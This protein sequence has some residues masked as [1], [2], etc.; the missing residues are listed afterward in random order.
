[1]DKQI[2]ISESTLNEVMGILGQLPY[3]QVAGTVRKIQGEAL[4]QLSLPSEMPTP[5]APTE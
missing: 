3:A 5:P 4:P 2:S 1:M